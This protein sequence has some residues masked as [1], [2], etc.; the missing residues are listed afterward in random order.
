[1]PATI[2]WGVISTATIAREQVIPAIKAARDNVVLAVA[3]RDAGRARV[4]ADSLG[5]ERAYGSYEALLADPDIDAIYIPL[6]ND[7][8]APWSI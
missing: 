8:H 5:I 4:Y 1:M 6:P 7:G 3:S 2:R